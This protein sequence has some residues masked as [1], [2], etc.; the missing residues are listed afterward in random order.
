[1]HYVYLVFRDVGTDQIINPDLHTA[2]INILSQY[3]NILNSNR[4]KINSGVEY[5]IVIRSRTD[6]CPMKKFELDLDL[7]Y[8]YFAYI[9]GLEWNTTHISD[10]MSISNICNADIYT[11]LYNT[12][13]HIYHSGIQFCPHRLAMGQLIN[14]GVKSRSIMGKDWKLARINDV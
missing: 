4:L 9:D 8:M 14:N 1:M 7:A 13:A 3:Y 12:Y 11:N 6:F 5:D 10:V 2:P